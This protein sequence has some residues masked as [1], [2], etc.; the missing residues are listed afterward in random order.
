MAE[1]TDVLSD[2]SGRLGTQNKLVKELQLINSG[3]R[4][5]LNKSI[6]LLP[7]KK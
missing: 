3:L 2:I 1:I 7:V 4:N 6:S 5:R